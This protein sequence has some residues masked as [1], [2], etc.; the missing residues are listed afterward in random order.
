MC[1]CVHVHVH[2]SYGAVDTTAATWGGST[3]N[4]ELSTLDNTQE[5]GGGTNAD[6]TSYCTLFLYTC[7]YSYMYSV[8]YLFCKIFSIF[9][10]SSSGPFFS[11]FTMY[12]SSL[13]LSY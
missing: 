1:V 2:C 5:L 7:S 11:V 4:S 9:L 6:G 12:D 8:V 13:M 10:L 3:M